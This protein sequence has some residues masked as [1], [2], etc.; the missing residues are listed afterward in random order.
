MS[1]RYGLSMI[2]ESRI[3]I[4]QDKGISCQILLF[5]SHMTKLMMSDGNIKGHSLY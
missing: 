4:A 2:N 5:V 3:F 1:L